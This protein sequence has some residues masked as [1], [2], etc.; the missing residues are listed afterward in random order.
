VAFRKPLNLAYDDRYR[1]A[2]GYYFHILEERHVPVELLGDRVLDLGAGTGRLVT[3]LR[4]QTGVLVEMDLSLDRLMVASGKAEKDN[5]VV[6]I[7]AD[8][9]AMPLKDNTISGVVCLGTFEYVHGL[10]PL[11][12]KIRRLC[13]DKVLL[14]FT[15]YNR[16]RWLRRSFLGRLGNKCA[17]HALED[18]A[19]ELQTNGFCVLSGK[20]LLLMPRRLF[21]AVYSLVPWKFLR[22]GWVLLCI[23]IELFLGALPSLKERGQELMVSARVVK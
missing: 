10:S 21:W 4:R 3:L 15:C 5:G 14:V 20:S 12:K 16:R 2:L 7:C 1:G 11:L 8:G 6:I 17:E 9:S 19:F 23:A 18:I 13:S 22:D